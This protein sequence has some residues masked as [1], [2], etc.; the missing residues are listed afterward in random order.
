VTKNPDNKRK[1]MRDPIGML[2][3]LTPDET[4]ARQAELSAV[5]IEL[6]KLEL[7]K[8][9]LLRRLKERIDPVA[10]RRHNLCRVIE[11]NKEWRDVECYELHVYATNSVEIRRVDNDELYERRV[12]TLG[13]RQGEMFGTPDELDDEPDEPEPELASAKP[14]RRPRKPARGTA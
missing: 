12:M 7:E 9:E 3:T 11:S 4:L 14:V 5:D 8:K 10:S 6:I 2:V 1:P 13:E